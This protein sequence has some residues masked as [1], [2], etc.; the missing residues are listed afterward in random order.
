MQSCQY[1][2]WIFFVLIVSNVYFADCLRNLVPIGLDEEEMSMTPAGLRPAH[3]GYRLLSNSR[4]VVN[5]EERLVYFPDESIPYRIPPCK[6]ANSTIPTK[7]SGRIAY[8]SSVSNSSYTYLNGSWR[9]PEPPSRASEQLIYLFIGL[10]NASSVIIEPVLQWGKITSGW[11][12]L[13][14]YCKLD[15]FF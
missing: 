7:F 12:F 11:G 2:F 8:A 3:C 10:E 13:L 14:G 5:K 4:V 6:K 9:V 15:R 1:A